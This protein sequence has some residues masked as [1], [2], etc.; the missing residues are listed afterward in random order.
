MAGRR[1]DRPRRVTLPG[2]L[3][4]IPS[5]SLCEAELEV[6][7]PL[8]P[9]DRAL[10]EV[11]GTI[12]P[13]D[14]LIEHVRDPRID[15]VTI[16]PGEGQTVPTAG[17]RWTPAED[18]GRGR[19]AQHDG[20]GELLSRIPGRGDRWR[21][22]TGEHRDTLTSPVGGTIT[23][24]LPGARIGVRIAGRAIRAAFAAGSAARGPL[25]LATDSSGE[26]RPGGIDVAR[27]GGILVAGSRIDAE[28]LTRARAMGVRGIVVGSLAGKD[29]RDFVAS[30]RRQAATLHGM[31]PFGVLALG[32]M[33]RRPIP[34]PLA[35][36][37]ERVAGHEV[38]LL[39][40][41]PLLVFDDATVELPEIEP[42]WVWIRSGPSAGAE[43]RVLGLS[44]RRRF[45]GN[46]VLDV[47]RVSF[48]GQ[49]PIDVPLGDLERF[50]A[51]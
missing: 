20:G 21:I 13:G 14:P 23:E 11:G 48:A 18:D 27:A 37:L 16:P 49:S 40:D 24:I 28:A 4:E 44:G 6:R 30:E 10:V 2:W 39:V 43:G 50:S 17:G 5:R 47:A 9:G 8:P 12:A 33:V 25:Q 41:P 51:A 22:V 15:E 36:L 26:L 35:A 34:S 7:L 19:H 45:A 46:I 29:L 1:V 31:A 38:A 42:D 32:G 3:V